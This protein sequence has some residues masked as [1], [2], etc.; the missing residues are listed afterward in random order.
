MLAIILAGGKGTRMLSDFPKCMVPL[1][2]KPMILYLINTL[3]EINVDKIYIVVS[4][5][6]EIIKKTIQEDVIFIEQTNPLGTADAVKSCKNVLTNINDDILILAAD[7]PLI[8]KEVLLELMNKHLNSQND[9]TI[10]STYMDE[11]IGL[12]R[13]IRKNG[14]IMKIVEE[15]E[16]NNNEDIK[17]VNTS[18]YC[19]KS[20]VLID[21]I[22]RINNNNRSQEYYFTDIVEILSK[23]YQIDVYNTEY[24][25]HLQGINDIETLQ[26]LESMME[27]YER[28]N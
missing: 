1:C 3:K 6:K 15:K 27:I 5:K 12:G 21:N 13:I 11:P 20:N 28:N 4:Y 16:L 10:L 24:T 18:I 2:G 9:L 17:E 8:K 23:E 7:M 25:Y 22:D 26:K 19:I 14:K